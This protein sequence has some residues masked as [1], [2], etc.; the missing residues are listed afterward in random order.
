MK[1]SS[2]QY[3]IAKPH[4]RKSGLT[5]KDFIAFSYKVHGWRV[6]AYRECGYGKRM[7]AAYRQLMLNPERG[8][9]W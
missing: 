4:I 8:Y 3:G 7:C 5:G 2:K 9:V 1:Q 6:I